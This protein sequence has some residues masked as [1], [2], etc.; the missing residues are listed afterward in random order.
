M[1]SSS[2]LSNGRVRKGH[3]RRA[4]LAGLAALAGVGFASSAFAG[5]TTINPPAPGEQTIPDIF[6]HIYGGTFTLEDGVDY[7]NGS[8]TAVRV[9][10]TAPQ[11][12]GLSYDDPGPNATDQLWQASS[13]S[14]TAEASFSTLES[15]PFGYIAGS[16]GG[17]FTPLFTVSGHDYDTTGSG[18]FSLGSGTFRLAAENHYG[19][20]S[21]LPAD[22]V[23]TADSSKDGAVH[24]V[25]YE[26][27]GLSGPDKT[28]LAFFDDY[29]DDGKD[30]DFDYEDLV[31]QLKTAPAATSSVPEPAGLMMVGGTMLALFKRYRRSPRGT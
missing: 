2:H 22:N 31:I 16:S 5:F 26:I 8:L 17:S 13:V 4:V 20:L 24:M 15:S 1:D 18:S 30:G 3:L 21:S 7:S 12:G 23:D 14:V 28:W 27:D 11:S 6:G 9:S 29:G 19:L 25:T 10:D